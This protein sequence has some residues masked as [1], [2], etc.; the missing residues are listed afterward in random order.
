M[1][2]RVEFRSDLVSENIPFLNAYCE[3]FFCSKRVSY[4][5]WER[6]PPTEASDLESDILIKYENWEKGLV[7]WREKGSPHI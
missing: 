3:T 5:V 1:I 7:R 2:N 6:S 4:L